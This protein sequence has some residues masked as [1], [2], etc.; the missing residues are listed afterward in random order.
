MSHG[1]APGP[2]R[3]QAPDNPT[4]E[5]VREELG[6]VLA[7]HEFRTSKRSQDFLKYVVENTLQ[8]HADMLKERTIGIEVFGRSTSYDPSDD[9][10][11][12]V[13]AGEVRKRLGLYYSTEGAHN[14]LRIELP[15]GTYVP[16]FHPV[17][18]PG[19]AARA[20]E[21]AAATPASPP[22]APRRLA[23]FAAPAAVALAAIAVTAWLLLR[24]A[25]GPLDEFWAPVFTGS[26]PVLVC[27]AFVP[28]WARDRDSNPSL[29]VRT[30]D[31]VKLNDQFVGG[32]DLIATSRLTAMLGRLHRPYRLKVGADAFTDLRAGPAILVGYSYTR[33]K[34]ISIQMR[35]FIR[36]SVGFVGIT[37]NGR[38]TDWSLPDLPPDRHTS[39]DYAIVS[40]VFHPDTHAMLVE[41]AGIT[42][43]GTD[44][45]SDLVT[46]PDLMAEAVRG[47]PGW[48]HKNLQLVL[49]VK[50]ISGA[51]ASPKIVAR[52]F[53]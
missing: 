3:A 51:P 29:P 44:A 33:W 52:Y 38:Q 39:E 28:V 14:P 9:A 40:R 21:A 22:P 45:A 13:K 47:Q 26:S 37:D 7:S 46:N 15:S 31:F 49:R 41:L 12:R 2:A 53:W 24:P 35:Y 43:Y 50:V 23:R 6:R 17:A 1:H 36:V 8:G 32:G 27:A 30:E 34:E 18:D 20:P 16:E 42:Q 48:Q 10:T 11:V 4:E 19:P 25:A 5:Q